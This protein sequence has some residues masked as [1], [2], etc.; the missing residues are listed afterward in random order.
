MA[1]PRSLFRLS[2]ERLGIL[3]MVCCLGSQAQVFSQE[4]DENPFPLTSTD[5]ILYAS[6]PNTT[7]VNSLLLL[8]DVQVPSPP[9]QEVLAFPGAE[10]FGARATGGRNGQVLKVTT[11]TGDGNVPGSLQWAINQAGPRIIVFAVSGVIQGDIR[12]PHGDLTIAGQT[13]PGA[14]ITIVGHLY[15]PYRS[16]VSNMIIRHLRI[17][18]PDPDG[19]WPPHQHDAIQF[20]AAHNFILD[21]IDASHGA[22]EIIDF[23][24]GA[25]DITIQWSTITFPLYDPDGANALQHPKGLI[26]HR[27]C[28]DGNGCDTNDPLGGRISVHHNLF[29]HCENRTP[30]LSTGPADTI[31]N[32]IYNGREGFVH[33]NIVGSSSTDPTAVGEF[34]IIGNYYIEGGS[35]SLAPFWFDPENG[36]SPIP[37]IYYLWDNY[38]EDPGDFVGRVD[39]PFSNSSFDDAY[40]FSCCGITPGQFANDTPFDFTSSYANY[41]PISVQRPQAAYDAVLQKAGAWPRDI[42]TTWA[43]DET[44]NRSGSWGIRRPSDWLTGLTPGDPPIDNDNDGIADYWEDANGLNPDDGNDHN[45]VMPSGYSAIEEYINELAVSIVGN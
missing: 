21:H 4:G 30:A 16:P 18:P 10:G 38:V 33:H 41:V 43:V 45:T 39:N 11:L 31:N 17:R 34:N 32:V 12:I 14:G 20:S 28:I 42:V 26:N 37:S 22:D 2:I 7:P 19:E 36:T 29:A 3:L 44:T 35:T 13:A 27:S 1:H 40:T 23:W 15:T 6:V 24:Y 8:G 5:S 25:Y 9:P